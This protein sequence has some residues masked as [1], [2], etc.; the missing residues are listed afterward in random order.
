MFIDYKFKLF[1]SNYQNIFLLFRVF[2]FYRNILKFF[3]NNL[4]ISKLFHYF[5]KYIIGNYIEIAN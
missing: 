5:G 3:R 4:V 1:L 2:R